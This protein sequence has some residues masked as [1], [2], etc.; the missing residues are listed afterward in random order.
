MRWRRK[1]EKVLSLEEA[2][3]RIIPLR[4]QDLSKK[5]REEFLY[6]KPGYFAVGIPM[7]ETKSALLHID[8]DAYLSRIQELQDNPED[9]FRDVSLLDEIAYALLKPVITIEAA[10]LGGVPY[11][12]MKKRRQEG[13]PEATEADYSRHQEALAWCRRLYGFSDHILIRFEIEPGTEE[14][15]K[16]QFERELKPIYPLIHI[17]KDRGYCPHIDFINDKFGKGGLFVWW[18]YRNDAK[19]FGGTF[20]GG[21]GE[22]VFKESEKMDKRF[23]KALRETV[24]ALKKCESITAIYLNPGDSNPLIPTYKKEMPLG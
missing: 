1:M 13:L 10:L 22:H 11:E 12:I 9:I 17:K 15:F 4:F 2:M 24:D 14:G 5:A 7:D 16:E 21:S 3:G 6:K 23:V 20:G 18:D 8:L 19:F